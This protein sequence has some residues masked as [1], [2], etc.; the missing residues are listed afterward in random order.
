MFSEIEKMDDLMRTLIGSSAKLIDGQT[1]HLGKHW[2]SFCRDIESAENKAEAAKHLAKHDLKE[3][4]YFFWKFFSL[5]F[6]QKIFKIFLAP[7]KP[8]ENVVVPSLTTHSRIVT[9]KKKEVKPPEKNGGAGGGGVWVEKLVEPKRKVLKM[10]QNSWEGDNNTELTR[11][12]TNYCRY[13][14]LRIC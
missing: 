3:G 7:K 11:V 1:G 14:T 12:I 4:V 13:S 9:A 10:P 5:I 8:P 6:Y 2:S